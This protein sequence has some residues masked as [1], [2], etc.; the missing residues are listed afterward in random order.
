M[1]LIEFRFIVAEITG[2]D[3]AAARHIFGVEIDND[4]RFSLEVIERNDRPVSGNSFEFWRVL[5]DLK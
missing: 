5:P 1:K 4:I 3:R 2:F